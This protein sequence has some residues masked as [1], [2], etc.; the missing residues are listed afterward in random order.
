MFKIA[1][2]VW[3]MLGTVFAGVGLTLLLTVPQLS[4]D[5][6]R[7]IPIVVIATAILAIPFSVMVA[8][9]IQAMTAGR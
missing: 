8:K 4:H 2:L 6:M 7:M 3:I 5:P 9:R 1:L